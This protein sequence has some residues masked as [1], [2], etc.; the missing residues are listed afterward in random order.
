[1]LF[2]TVDVSLF[3]SLVNRCTPTPYLNPEL[4]RSDRGN[5]KVSWHLNSRMNN[6][7]DIA[8]VKRNR[9]KSSTPDDFD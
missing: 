2:C 7:A 9:R 4:Y 3:K 8:T 6:G 5:L 1:M